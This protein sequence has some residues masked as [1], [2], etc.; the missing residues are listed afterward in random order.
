[1]GVT[2]YPCLSGLAG[3]RRL[4]RSPGRRRAEAGREV[5]GVPGVDDPLGDPLEGLGVGEVG[6]K[7]R[8]QGGWAAHKS[9]G[10]SP[11]SFATLASMRGPISS[12]S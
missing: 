8:P 5:L 12:W 9:S 2:S 1:M 4:H 7:R 3:W 11:V 10:R 6:L